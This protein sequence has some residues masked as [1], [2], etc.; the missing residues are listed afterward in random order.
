[1]TIL[2]NLARICGWMA[3]ISF[4]LLVLGTVVGKLLKKRFKDLW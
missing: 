1:M 4:G 2:E 3:I